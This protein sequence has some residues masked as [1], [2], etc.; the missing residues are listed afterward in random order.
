MGCL[1]SPSTLILS[2][3]PMTLKMPVPQNPGCGL[4][5]VS[6][7]RTPIEKRLPN[8][9]SALSQ[10]SPKLYAAG[11][12]SA[13]CYIGPYL[14]LTDCILHINLFPANAWKPQSKLWAYLPMKLHPPEELEYGLFHRMRAS[15]HKVLGSIPDIAGIEGHIRN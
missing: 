4:F 6:P 13:P 1:R 11:H 9:Q 15:L 8:R 7:E 12:H 14:C 3:V 10:I 2:F 5:E